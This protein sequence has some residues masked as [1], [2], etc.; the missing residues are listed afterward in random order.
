MNGQR[1]SSSPVTITERPASQA[2]VDQQTSPDLLLMLGELKGQMSALILLMEQKRDD[3]NNLF[4]RIAL[5][6]KSAATAA[7]VAVSNA[8]LATIEKQLARWAGVVLCV[9]FLSPLVIPQIQN[10]LD[11]EA[12]EIRERYSPRPR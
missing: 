11:Y 12:T 4:T 6:E 7:D 3:I 1:N 10:L 9:A 8:K 2:M 5:L